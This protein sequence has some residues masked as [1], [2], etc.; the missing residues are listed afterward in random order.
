MDIE[1]V[2]TEG[3]SLLA[4]VP[5]ASGAAAGG[6]VPLLPRLLQMLPLPRRRRRKSQKRSLMMIWASGYLTKYI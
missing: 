4:S 2:M 1:K 5:G 6:L 3:M